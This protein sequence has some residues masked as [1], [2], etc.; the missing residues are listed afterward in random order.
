MSVQS[1]AATATLVA[2]A[3]SGIGFLWKHRDSVSILIGMEPSHKP[4]CDRTQQVQRGVVEVLDLNEKQCA[5][6]DSAYL[7]SI[8]DPDLSGKDLTG[9]QSLD[10]NNNLLS[11]LPAGLFDSLLNLKFLNMNEGVG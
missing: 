9:L 11:V 4:V 1:V 10:L 7:A 5:V 6:V 3:S 2:I 8:T